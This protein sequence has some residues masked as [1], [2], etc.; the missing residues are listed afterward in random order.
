MS[1]KLAINGGTPVRTKPM[2][3]HWPGA[4][5][6]DDEE[7]EA[8]S[9]V[10]RAKSPFREY[11]PDLQHE[12][13]KFEAEA[14]RFF[15]TKYALGVNSGTSA[16]LCAMAAAGVGPGQEVIVP[17]FMWVATV[18][19]VV[20]LGA[21]P[22]LA[23][24]DDTYNMDPR[25]LE[26]KITPNT[27]VVI[28]VHMRGTASNV[29][30]IMEVA[31]AA[32]LIV[33]EDSAQ[34]IGGSIDG[35]MLGSWGDMGCFSLQ[36]NKNVTTGEG[37]LFLTNDDVFIE[38]ARAWQDLGFQ[39]DGGKLTA[40]PGAPIIWGAGSRMAETTAALARV[41]LRKLPRIC[42]L[43]REHQQQVMRG[44]SD[45]KGFTFRSIVDPEGDSGYCVVFRLADG[46]TADWFAKAL[47]AEGIP[48]GSG[49][50]EGLHIYG[51]MPNLVEK[52]SISPD[53][54][55]WTHPA[56]VPLAREYGPG[57]LPQTDKLMQQ[58]LGIWMPPTMTEED[59]QDIVKAVRKVTAHLPT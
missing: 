55:P 3:E 34:A 48:C 15:G 58:F 50:E 19:A 2:P 47:R 6:Y 43:M 56:N 25:D 46:K 33:V 54:F 49:R 22:V 8:V 7:V 10:L 1:D 4:L 26:R 51:V 52:R 11:G 23:E 12:A 36:L 41:Q 40:P 45:L 32:N 13:Q 30:A 24:I 5:M 17:G 59:E 38:R 18:S 35:K 57:T 29:P 37:G 31:R 42:G 20:L 39:R 53:G 44:I 21:T 16:L 27:T 14:A 9:R 28:P